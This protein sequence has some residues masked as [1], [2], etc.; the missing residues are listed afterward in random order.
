MKTWQILGAVL[1]IVVLF[2]CR[3]EPRPLDAAAATRLAVSLANAET[4]RNHNTTP[5]SG[6]HGKIIMAGDRWSWQDL[7]G[8]GKGSLRATV[9]FDP[10][11]KNQKVDVQ[12]LVDELD[13]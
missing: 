9:S 3:S 8:Y 1:A 4:L 10:K 6:D 2:G 12:L 7:A 5:F 13:Y 11:G